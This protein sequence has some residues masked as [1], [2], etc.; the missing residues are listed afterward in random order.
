[1]LGASKHSVRDGL[2]A[3]SEPEP[4][5]AAS[6]GV[7]AFRI[8]G[9]RGVGGT[10]RA[11]SVGSALPVVRAGPGVLVDWPGVGAGAGPIPCGVPGVFGG[12]VIDWPGVGAGA[13]PMP[14]V[15][16]P[17]ALLE[18]G[19]LICAKANVAVPKRPSAVIAAAK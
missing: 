9:W 7:R 10:V 16:L 18:L 11:L 1:M 4:T 2:S 15:T 12:M 14:P 5:V 19:A 6:R 17:G 8:R 3:F 13:G